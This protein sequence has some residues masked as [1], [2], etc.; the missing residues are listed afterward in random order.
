MLFTALYNIAKCMTSSVDT[1]FN[2]L[3]DI[4]PVYRQKRHAPDEKFL[5]LR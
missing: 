5:S 3:C 4:L 2:S 1:D